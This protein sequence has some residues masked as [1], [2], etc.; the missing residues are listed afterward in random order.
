M[1]RRRAEEVRPLLRVAQSMAKELPG[2]REGARVKKG[3]SGFGDWEAFV[4]N[5]VGGGAV[6]NAS[7][8]SWS[9]RWERSHSRAM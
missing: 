4:R 9:V 5:A 3:E 6:P 2:A 7:P 8:T 1:R